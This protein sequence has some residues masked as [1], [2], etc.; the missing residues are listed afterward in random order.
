M[1]S[2]DLDSPLQ[3]ER[4]A[5]IAYIQSHQK[6]LESPK[7]LAS[8]SF[9]GAEPFFLSG[10]YWG[11]NSA[12]AL[13]SSDA[14]DYE[15]AVQKVLAAQCS[16]GAFGGNAGH[17]PHVL[18]TLSAVQCLLLCGMK[19]TNI[20]NVDLLVKFV[21]D[22]QNADGSF[23]GD[24]FGED[25]TRH[26]YAAIACLM[27][28]QRTSNIDMNAAC[29]HINKCQTLDGAYGV[30]PQSESHA[31]HTFCCVS[32]LAICG[33]LS[34]IKHKE[35]LLLWLSERQHFSGGCN[36]RPGKRVDVCYS[37]WVGATLALLGNTNNID[38]TSLTQ[39]ILS[40]Q[41][42]GGGMGAHAGDDADLFHTHFAITSLGALC[43]DQLDVDIDQID[44]RFCLP[45]PLLKS[46]NIQ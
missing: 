6:K 28:L 17:D 32:T 21:S 5:H 40:Q 20:P 23:S 15:W 36:G 39:S 46:L 38:V 16:N 44:A 18:Y 24:E 2:V 35:L 41:C 14:I 19:P 25:D 1:A 42:T 13:K 29:V 45:C 7:A 37:W 9:W 8:L 26:S 31:G 4:A 3:L 33:K 22:L 12:A 10:L 30:R 34:T 43:R 27:L 11:L